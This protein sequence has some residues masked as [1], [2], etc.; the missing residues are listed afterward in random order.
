MGDV[1]EA[2]S[3]GSGGGGVEVLLTL[4]NGLYETQLLPEPLLQARAKGQRDG[5]LANVLARRSHEDGPY[6]GSHCPVVTRCAHEGG[7][8]CRPNKLSYKSRYSW[9][10]VTQ[11]TRQK[12]PFGC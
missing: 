10:E 2:V 9:N 5:G 4:T 11:G 12:Q 7:E 6:F 8:N 3:M 1:M